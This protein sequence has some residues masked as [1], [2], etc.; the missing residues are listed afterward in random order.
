MSGPPPPPSP[1]PLTHHEDR[2]EQGSPD[3]LEGLQHYEPEQQPH[4]LAA[5]AAM[6]EYVRRC[7]ESVRSRLSQLYERHKLQVLGIQGL[8]EEKEVG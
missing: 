4:H 6:S 7:G 8:M 2:H 3:H 5:A 1:D